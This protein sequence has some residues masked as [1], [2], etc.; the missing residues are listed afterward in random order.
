[1]KTSNYIDCGENTFSS[2]MPRSIVATSKTAAYSVNGKQVRRLRKIILLAK[3][4]KS[5]KRRMIYTISKGCLNAGPTSAAVGP[6]FR[7]PLP[8]VSRKAFE[9]R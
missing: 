9:T 4:H 1:M 6:A 7:R 3:V 8:S 2:F 5:A